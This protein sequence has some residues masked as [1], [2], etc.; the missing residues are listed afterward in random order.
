MAAILAAVIIG[1]Y[2]IY[3]RFGLS[4]L[5][6]SVTLK[7]R[8][9]GEIKA[10][11][12]EILEA[13]EG[14]EFELIEELDN[15]KLLPLP[16]VRTEISCSRWLTF[17]GS[18]DSVA[19][20]DTQKGLISGIFT[21]KSRQK[22]RR[23]WRIRAEKRGVFTIDDVAITVSD[24]FGLVRSARVE[25]LSQKL[26]I[27]PTPTEIESGEM[28]V[29]AF[30]GDIPVRRFVLPDPF[31][32]SGARE[33]TGREPMNR[34]HWAQSARC[35]TLMVYCSEFTTERR[36]LIV[37]NIQRSFHGE[38]QM[39]SLPTLEAMIK[40]AAYMLERCA[41][42]HTEC[43]L[44]VNSAPLVNPVPGEGFAHTL[45]CLRTL[46]EL[47]GDCGEHIDDFLPPLN[48]RDYTDAVFISAFL[49]DRCEDVLRE[50]SERGVC[51]S[52]LSTEIESADFCEVRH[53]HKGSLR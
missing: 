8:D 27:L 6:Y 3:S 2:A 21:L 46:A 51:V 34:I 20:D 50:L 45:E 17:H 38:K 13:Y 35:G 43:A 52:V 10:G 33:Y 16:W 30:I 42:S 40:A 28:S 25:K 11:G 1:Q 19:K 39:M 5:N 44:A 37:L 53:I 9:G 15:A 26:R 36:V 4:R 14:E 22:C 7:R 31:V 49:D 29:D 47:S 24:L 32:I 41:E 48:F 12:D 23:T 18:R